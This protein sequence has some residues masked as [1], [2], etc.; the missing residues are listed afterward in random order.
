MKKIFVVLLIVL[1]LSIL[2]QARSD[3]EYV[4]T[5]EDGEA[6]VTR[7]VGTDSAVTVPS[8]LDGCPVRAIG[9]KAFYQTAVTEVA[10]PESVTYIGERA[11]AEC[12]SLVEFVFPDV[13]ED[14][15]GAVFYGCTSLTTVTM[16]STMYYIP[17]RTFYG[18]AAL[19]S[20]SM[21]MPN[22]VLSIGEEAFLGCAS[23]TAMHIRDCT[24]IVEDR[25]FADCDELFLVSVDTESLYFGA[26]VFA[27]SPKVRLIC[28]RGSKVAAYAETNGIDYVFITC[29]EHGE[30]ETVTVLPTETEDGVYIT[31]CKE[32]YFEFSREP[33]PETDFLYS[34]KDGEATVT[35][36]VGS[37]TEV[38]VPAAIH[39]YP[40]VSIGKE[41]FCGS[42]IAYLTVESGVRRIE[43][44]AFAYC[45]SLCD[46]DLPETL[47]Y[48]GD[49]AFAYSF[50][51]TFCEIRLPSSVT[52]MGDSVF[53]CCERLTSVDMPDSLTAL[54]NST[55]YACNNLRIVILPEGLAE[56]PTG[57]FYASR[58]GLEM[59]YIPKSVKRI[60]TNAFWQGDT[61]GVVLYTVC[62]GGS[63][64][65]FLKI[66]FAEGNTN[67]INHD[68]VFGAS[69]YSFDTRGG[70]P[71]EPYFATVPLSVLPT[72]VREGCV[73]AGW[74]DNAACTGER[75]TA[76][77]DPRSSI[78]LYARWKVTPAEKM[79]F[80]DDGVLS[81]ADALLGIR[82]LLNGFV[83][84]AHD[85][86]GDGQ[87]TLI[88]ILRILKTACE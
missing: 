45:R 67:L 73:F 44:Q 64:E 4:Y 42:K 15:G 49:E 78:T 83:T 61:L 86:S 58:M 24:S 31:R 19:E 17:E 80:S 41:A 79:D 75:L 26:D 40:I 12:T 54:G 81:V 18:C 69:A 37:D 63:A 22:G 5:I 59:L 47:L 56:I 76:P 52:E 20:G 68:I 28:Y 85:V 32:C 25:A 11:F 84:E 82:G 35:K 14:M 6:T 7:Y 34:Q 39:G 62:Y 33:M 66:T 57:T 9:G 1:S 65:D 3:G 2:A 27:A 36:Y 51:D 8:V 10:L 16:P 30:S 74:F 70:E 88:D 38:T 53:A 48:I 87:F 13:I 50:T 29:S 77:L 23:L 43:A 71:M 60:G 72:P 46:I 55:F 21:W